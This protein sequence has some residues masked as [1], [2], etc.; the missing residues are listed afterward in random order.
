MTR[1]PS[2]RLE[3]DRITVGQLAKYIDNRDGWSMHETKKPM[4]KNHDYLG[5]GTRRALQSWDDGRPKIIAEVAGGAP[6]PS[7]DEL[8][9][10]VP[11]EQWEI[12]LSGK[13]EPP[14]K[15]Q[16]IFYWLDLHDLTVMTFANSTLGAMR[17]VCDL[18]D[19]WDWAKAL[20]GDDV[21]PLIKPGD[22]PFPTQFGERRR[23]VFEIVGWRV[24]R[25]GALRA[26][27]TSVLALDAPRAKPL[28]EA[29][30]DSVPF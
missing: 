6:L 29:I 15:K 19:K 21:R 10:Q 9:A 3:P 14:W 28:T 11:E 22:A 13:P 18:E 2:I 4:P 27:D 23:P 7:V 1:L 24:F 8:N 20:Y 16:F 26:V 12:G 30:G 25:D 17:A 5:L